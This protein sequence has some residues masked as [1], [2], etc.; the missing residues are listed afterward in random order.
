MHRRGARG[1]TGDCVRTLEQ[2]LSAASDRLK[3]GARNKGFTPKGKGIQAMA[4]QFVGKASEINDG[5]RRIVFV[6]EHEIGVF[7]EKGE[8]YAY[9]NF[10]LHQGGPAC[11][12]LTIA[13]VEERIMPDKTS[14]GLYFSDT[15]MHFVCPWHGMEYDMKTGECVSDRRLKLRKYKIVQKGDDIYV[16]A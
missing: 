5:D 4:E 9:S 6:G 13:K 3:I 7:K 1:C 8:F 16:V 12:G 11:E 2:A 15:E 14:R 10:C